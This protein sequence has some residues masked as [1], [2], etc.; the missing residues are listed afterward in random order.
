M[1]RDQLAYWEAQID[2][3]DPVKPHKSMLKDEKHKVTEMIRVGVRVPRLVGDR[4]RSIKGWAYNR[5]MTIDTTT[6]LQHNR[7]HF[8][9]LACGMA[10]SPSEVYAEALEDCKCYLDQVD[11]LFD[12]AARRAV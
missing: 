7:W 11:E 9:G 5:G 3:D 8:I 10:G 12:E 1:N 4:A 2:F 6:G